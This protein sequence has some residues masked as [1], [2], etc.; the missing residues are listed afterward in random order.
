MTTTAR[1]L[2]RFFVGAKAITVTLRVRN[3]LKEEPPSIGTASS[4]RRTWMV[5]W[6]SFHGI[7]PVGMYEYKFKVNRNAPTR[8]TAILGS[9]AARRILRCA[10]S[11]DA[12]GAPEPFSVTTVITSLLLSDWTV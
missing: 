8:I 1:S 7:A 5:F 2:G 4:C 9:G 6:L 3:R 12:N 10:W 11:I